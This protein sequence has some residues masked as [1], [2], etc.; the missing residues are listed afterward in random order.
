[1]AL[2]WAIL[3]RAFSAKKKMHTL[4]DRSLSKMVFAVERDKDMITLLI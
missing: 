3:F 2:P 4:V 1:M